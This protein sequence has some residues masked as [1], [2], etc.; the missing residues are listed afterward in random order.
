MQRW[1]IHETVLL[2]SVLKR[3]L[4]VC[5]FL[6]AVSNFSVSFIGLSRPHSSTY[7][8][9][10]QSFICSKDFPIH[11]P[12]F[13]VMPLHLVFYFFSV[14]NP[15]LQ[16]FYCIS[17]VFYLR[18]NFL[19]GSLSSYFCFILIFHVSLYAYLRISQIFPKYLNCHAMILLAV[20]IIMT[21]I[22]IYFK[23]NRPI[24][25]NLYKLS[26]RNTKLFVSKHIW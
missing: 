3:N 24:H 22:W 17:F 4:L 10:R 14:L 26:S 20:R 9:S 13:S 25:I 15:T 7:F 16:Q 2:T 11:C 6:F 19:S 21:R 12:N 5:L 18:C 23:I 1:T 8:I